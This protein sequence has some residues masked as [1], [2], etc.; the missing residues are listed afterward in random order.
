MTMLPALDYSDVV[1][2]TYK[3]YLKALR[4]SAY[5]GEVSCQYSARLAVATDNSVYQQIPQ[6]VL[7]PK[8]VEDIKLITS[9]ASQSLFSEIQFSARGGGT[10]S[11]GQ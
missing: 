8:S 2:P 5:K 10:G 1:S 3:K 9:I 7:H 11:N 6:A 4:K